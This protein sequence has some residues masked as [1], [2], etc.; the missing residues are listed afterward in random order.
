HRQLV[1]EVRRH[2]QGPRRGAAPMAAESGRESPGLSDQLFAEAHRF[3]FFQ[4]V[5]LLEWVVRRRAEEK[6]NEPAQPV[7]RDAPPERAAVPSRPPPPLTS[8]AS[9][10]GQLQQPPANGHVPPPE[11]T[12]AFLGLTG[13]T[14][15]LP[16]HYTRL[17][18]SR[19]REK[20]HA[21]RRFL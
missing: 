8:P 15:V 20:D 1:L 19:L 21:L 16:Y 5:R 3:D 6:A 7:G 12:V 14:G 18:L 13:P 10:I 9:S 11:M 2:R 4:A 17:L